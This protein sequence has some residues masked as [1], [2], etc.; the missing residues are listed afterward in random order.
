MTVLRKV[1]QY[2]FVC[3]ALRVYICRKR[4]E[5]VCLIYFSIPRA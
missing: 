1:R 2:L 5:I 4:E 3:N